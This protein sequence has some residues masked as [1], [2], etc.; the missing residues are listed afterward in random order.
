[1]LRSPIPTHAERIAIGGETAWI[2]KTES[3]WRVLQGPYQVAVE[4]WNRQGEDWHSF[5]F[6]NASP[7]GG[8]VAFGGGTGAAGHLDRSAFIDVA[9]RIIQDLRNRDAPPFP[10]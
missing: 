3:G 2:W 10:P 5:D 1:V 4:N 7:R 6:D 9:Q 8:G